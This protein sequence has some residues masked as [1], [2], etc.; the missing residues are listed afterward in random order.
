MPI[1]TVSVGDVREAKFHSVVEDISDLALYWDRLALA[2][3]HAALRRRHEKQ[4]LT[5]S[6]GGS[7]CVPVFYNWR[8]AAAALRSGEPSKIVANPLFGNYQ[9]EQD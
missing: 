3:F 8:R 9:S 6:L 4:N 2:P 7:V 1:F 5:L